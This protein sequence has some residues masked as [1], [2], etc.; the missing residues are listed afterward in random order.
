MARR[1][2]LGSP[3]WQEIISRLNRAIGP[4]HIQKTASD[5][6]LHT[7]RLDLVLLGN[8]GLTVENLIRTCRAFNLSPNWVLLNEGEPELTKT[9]LSHKKIAELAKRVDAGIKRIK[10]KTAREKLELELKN[11]LGRLNQQ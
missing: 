2:Y 8:K 3:E 5:A 9:S 10:E 7:F 4:T 11:L 6:G 1:K